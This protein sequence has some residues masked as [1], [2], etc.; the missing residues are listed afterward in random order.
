MPFQKKERKERNTK[1][2]IYYLIT[3]FSVYAYFLF[4]KVNFA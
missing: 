3:D 2:G 1:F 4:T